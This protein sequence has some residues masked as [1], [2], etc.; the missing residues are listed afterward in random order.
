M[1][2]R[3][4]IS[5]FVQKNL[6]SKMQRISRS[7]V[8]N[9]LETKDYNSNDSPWGTMMSRGVWARCHT[10]RYIMD[11]NQKVVEELGIM[12]LSSAYKEG[13]VVQEH[14]STQNPLKSRSKKGNIYTLD[15]SEIFRGASGITNISVDTKN[16]F[17][18]K[19]T[20]SFQIPNPREFDI[21]Q[22]GFLRH[23]NLIF[24]EFGYSTEE[25]DTGV[26]Y[27]K[28]DFSSFVN[29]QSRLTKINETSKGNY[30]GML[31]VI[32]DF[33]F[34]INNSG[35]YECSFTIA[36]QGI[37]VLGQHIQKG[38][39]DDIIGRIAESKEEVSEETTNRFM[40]NFTAF[41]SVI[42]NLDDVVKEYCK[43]GSSKPTPY[44]GGKGSYQY[45][46]G[47]LHIVDWP[48]I[49]WF[50][51]GER[52]Q[53]D[54]VSWGWFEDV[55]LNTYFSFMSK[56]VPGNSL[57]DG[58]IDEK[59]R[60]SIRSTTLIENDGKLTE[61]N[62]TC[63][64]HPYLVSH[65]LTTCI[66]PGNNKFP[67]K[68][69]GQEEIV[70]LFQ[71]IDSKFPRFEIK[72]LTGTPFDKNPN[73]A[74]SNVGVIRN[75]VFPV[76][77]L[78][79][80]FKGITSIE[81]GLK[82]FWGAVSSLYGNFW[83]FDVVNDDMDTGRIGMVEYFGSSGVATNLDYYTN[84][85]D[86]VSNSTK[87]INDYLTY[88]GTK[89]DPQRMFLMPIYSDNS[90]VKDFSL[91]VKM[92]SQMATQAVYGSQADIELSGGSPPQGMDD[93][94]VRALGMLFNSSGQST[95]HKKSTPDEVMKELT[96]AIEQNL[97]PG[98]TI[99]RKQ[100]AH[101][102]PLAA[103]SYF[104]FDFSSVDD[105]DKSTSKKIKRLQKANE[106]YGNKSVDEIADELKEEGKYL[107]WPESDLSKVYTKSGE[108]DE[109]F[110]KIHNF[111]INEAQGT[112]NAGK[113]YK[114]VIPIPIR[115]SLTID[116]LGGLRIG[117][118][119]VVDYLPEVYRQC[120]HFMITK[121]G[122][123]VTPSGWFTKI[124]AVMQI[125]GEKLREIRGGQASDDDLQKLIKNYDGFSDLDEAYD[126]LAEKLRGKTKASNNSN[127]KNTSYWGGGAGSITNPAKE[128]EDNV[129][130]AIKTGK[131]FKTT[132]GHVYKS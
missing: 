77:F 3:T 46:N 36:S 26:S 108:M 43:V 111:L 25:M 32:V 71:L 126:D 98:S 119:F 73:P 80:H 11:D 129:Q 4:H 42:E 96:F 45:R 123:D 125:N 63:N 105:V 22:E 51:W 70:K 49:D 28:T 110:E 24:L 124:E 106:E 114:A 55:V 84:Y 97:T 65:G 47:A 117:N 121:I 39:P 85:K 128:Y 116:G 76:Q 72:E 19:A 88:N 107:F 90:I 38:G 31:G 59:F 61:E 103:N 92:N 113:F 104:G 8:N 75:M 100:V 48:N 27:E 23:G 91:D 16:F 89:K 9:I 2:F 122:H 112:F 30:H 57:V 130:E 7:K 118:L 33:S 20:V 102:K 115:L 99:T 131:T 94:G 109:Y 95:P 17:M 21:L 127:R 64:S 12:R 66:L 53:R 93:L 79:Q 83:A 14:I 68:A 69:S 6:L 67:K 18:N 37:N 10:P 34:N 41:E 78:Q 29:L 15:R 74:M 81:Q 87:N 82:S 13:V 101:P 1:K 40:K 54:Y 86:L 52:P 132:T 35:V 62:N 60:T 56:Q 5:P 44:F 50:R 58:T 120:T